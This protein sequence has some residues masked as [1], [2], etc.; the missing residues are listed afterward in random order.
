MGA[1]KDNTEAPVCPDAELGLRFGG[2]Q[3]SRIILPVMQAD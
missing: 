3:G 2:E 1:D